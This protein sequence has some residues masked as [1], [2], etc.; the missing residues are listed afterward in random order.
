MIRLLPDGVVVGE[1][2]HAQVLLGLFRNA[3]GG[4]HVGVLHKSS[5]DEPPEVLH[6][7]VDA[8]VSNEAVS[9]FASSAKSGLVWVTPRLD[10]DQVLGFV[11]RCRSVARTQSGIKQ[12]RFG[13]S[14]SKESGFNDE[15]QL[16]L[17]V[18]DIGLTCATFVASL[19][20]LC[21][22]RLLREEEWPIRA[23]SDRRLREWMAN[24]VERYD[25]EHAAKLRNEKA[26]RRYRPLEVA[27]GSRSP[28]CGFKAA[29]KFADAI[30]KHVL[31]HGLV[32]AAGLTFDPPS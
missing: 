24:Y 6:L 21:G 11:G 28:P 15:G 3:I 17:D 16:E 18:H 30:E 5:P 9:S 2:P 27:A 23:L 19:F 32:E 12:V 10:Q 7:E 4:W 22:I 29:T 8:K 13:L 31:L 20:R 1:P 14:Y 26:C 25:S